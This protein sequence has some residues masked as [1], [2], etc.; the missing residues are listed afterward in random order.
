MF[1]LEKLEEVFS[2]SKFECIQLYLNL[3]KEKNLIKDLLNELEVVKSRVK[4]LE[5]FES[6][7]EKVELSLKDDFIKLKLFI[8]MLV[9]ERKNMMEKI[10]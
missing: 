2:K 10:K 8:V 6:R 5:C 3:E 7:L 1:E 9:D 4:E